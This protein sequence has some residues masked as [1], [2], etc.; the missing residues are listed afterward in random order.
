MPMNENDKTRTFS[1]L[2]DKEIEMKQ[3]L[4]TVYEALSEKS[5]HPLDQ[6]VGYLISEDPTYITNY[7]NA[8]SL[9]RKVDRIE[10]LNTLVKSYLGL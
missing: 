9:I 2:D 4:T 1:I 5:Y 3:V 7:K 10:L 8:R 6:I